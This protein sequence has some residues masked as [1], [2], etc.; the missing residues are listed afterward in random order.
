MA[1]LYPVK[2]EETERVHAILEEKKKKKR[3]VEREKIKVHQLK[4]KRGG[5]SLLFIH[6]EGKRGVGGRKLQ[7]K[8]KE[9]A[10]SLEREGGLYASLF[11]ERETDVRNGRRP[12]EPGATS[13]K[14]KKSSK[15]GG[16]GGVG[17][18]GSP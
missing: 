12:S 6:I 9:S 10:L 5:K 14:K 11:R 3:T 4:R 16:G 17:L 15:K 13:R 1:T 8:K 18:G 2:W 7:E